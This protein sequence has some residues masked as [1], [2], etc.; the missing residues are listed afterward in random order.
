M[1][2]RE[3][4]YR[5]GVANIIINVSDIE[6]IHG[7]GLSGQHIVPP[8]KEGEPFGILIVYPTPEIQDIGDERR[9][10]HWLKATP[11]AKDICGMRSSDGQYT[12]LGVL[13]C[14]AE[15]DLSRDLEK[16]L[17]EEINFLNDNIPE[18][19]YKKTKE[20]ALVA[21]NV[22]T[23]DVRDHKIKLSKAVVQERNRFEKMCRTLVTKE[24]VA[25]ARDSML[26]TAAKLVADGD[27]LWAAGGDNHKNISELVKWACRLLG[28]ERPWCYIPVAQFPCP[29]CGKPCR[30]NV[31][32]CPACGA[33]FDREIEDY[34]KMTNAEKARSLYPDRYLEP[35][36][37]G[38]PAKK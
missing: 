29:G 8:K 34:A 20:G 7:N 21:Y 18:V 1:P 24:E 23:D 37:A 30:E 32:T 3:D 31:I 9:T 4:F 6:I 28:Q 17:E 22:E 16:A 14:T 27:T 19:K 36:G 25:K 35:A 11:L 12:R 15:P 38:A 5:R 13:L 10:V 26:R 33:I 2:D